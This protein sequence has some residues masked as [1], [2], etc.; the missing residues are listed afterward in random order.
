MGACYLSLMD[1]QVELSECDSEAMVQY[2]GCSLM[3]PST[4]FLLLTIQM[5]R[6]IYTS[7]CR[8]ATTFVITFV[9]TAV[10]HYLHCDSHN[11]CP[12]FLT[13]SQT[14]PPTLPSEQ[15]RNAQRQSHKSPAHSV[16]NYLSCNS[17][18]EYCPSN[19]SLSC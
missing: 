8:G 7:F 5:T 3:R 18:Q 12:S 4:M 6:C 17:S 11:I 15:D 13:S 19:L 1:F 9:C 10:R 16:H 14:K 2:T